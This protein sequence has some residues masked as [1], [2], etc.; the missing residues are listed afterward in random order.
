MS[1]SNYG[2]MMESGRVGVASTGC[3]TILCD[4]IISLPYH[5]ESTAAHQIDGNCD[6]FEVNE[7]VA[8]SP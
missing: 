1:A 2:K 8:N 7:V 6:N 4:P 3:A 5:T